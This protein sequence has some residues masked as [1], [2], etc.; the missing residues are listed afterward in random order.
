MDSLWQDIRYA[1]RALRKAPG[2]TVLVV[3]SLALAIAGNTAVFSLINGILYRPMPYEEPERLVLIGEYQDPNLAGQINRASSANFLDWRERAKGF[4]GMA[5]YNPDQVNLGPPESAE[6]V[7]AAAVTPSF[8]PVLG[9]EPV[10]GRGFLGEEGRPGADRVVV[11][12]YGFWQRRLGGEPD[13]LGRE[14]ILDGETNSVVGVL[15]ER[16]EFLDPS[17]DIWRPLAF[18]TGPEGVQSRRTRRD[19]LVVA[20]LAPGVSTEEAGASMASLGERLAREHPDANRGYQTEV[21]NLRENVPSSRD[22]QLLGLIQGALVFV[23]LIACANVANLLL[24]RTQARVT[25]MAVRSSLGAGRWRLARQLAVEA[26]VAAGVGGALGLAGGAVVTRAMADAFAARI[27]R[28]WLPAI[29]LRVVLFTAGASVFAGLLVGL[30]PAAQIARLKVQTALKEGGRGSSLGGRRR[31]LTKGLVVAEIA[32]ALVLLGGGS[33]LIRSFLDIQQRDPGFDTEGLAAFQVTLPEAKYDSPGARATAIDQVVQ[34]VAELPGIVGAAAATAR[35]RTPVL[36]AEPYT[37][38]GEPTPE[39]QAA[40]TTGVLAA[41]PE[42]FATVGIDL[43]EGRG[44]E[45]T[46]APGAAPVVLVNASFAARHWPGADP[47]GRQITVR[48]EPRRIVGVVADVIHGVFFQRE[49]QPTVYLPLAQLAPG[50]AVITFRVDGDPTGLANPVRDAVTAFEP[51][52]VVTQ[53]STVDEFTDQFFVGMRVISSILGVFGALAL[54]LA[55]LGTYGVLA[56][57][58]VQRTHEIGVRMA[59]GAKG[60]E[61]RRMVTKQGLALAALGI[62][63][64]VPGVI[65]V[66]R[67]IGSTMTNTAEAQPLTVLAVALVLAVVTVVASWMPARRAAAVDPL[68]AL[69]GE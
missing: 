47:V 29:D 4:E 22:R 68:T 58:V 67:V 1:V 30:L 9:V 61:V 31:L 60:G 64:G 39:G 2:V 43:L 37:V 46:D 63:L 36:P 16:F 26:M 25:E 6:P 21:L 12:S 11:L 5:G 7:T 41:S 69:R 45:A 66:T 55:A 17:V 10:V 23:L 38:T 52:L 48:G 8:L 44:F 24:A 49:Q 40:P 13:V 51:G 59:L 34:R 15:P 28:F 32:L 65:V 27:P 14:V 18:D 56:Y 57:S 3:G 19:L 35:P 54:L 42:L 62:S 20:R 33:V 53:V 50:G